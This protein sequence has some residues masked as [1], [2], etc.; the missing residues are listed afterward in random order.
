MKFGLIEAIVEA[1]AKVPISWQRCIVIGWYSNLMLTGNVHDWSKIC[2][3]VDDKWLLQAQSLHLRKKSSSL[4]YSCVQQW[5]S[6]KR[7]LLLHIHYRMA[8]R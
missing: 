8:D 2:G 5:E 7:S 4:S 6:F 3:Q 1:F